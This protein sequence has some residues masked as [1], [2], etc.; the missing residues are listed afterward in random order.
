MVA[1][2][3]SSGTATYGGDSLP[4][5]RIV[6]MQ[7]TGHSHYTHND[8]STFAIVGENDGIVSPEVMKRRIINL[9]S[10]GIDTEFHQYPNVG[11]GFGLGTGTSAEGWINNAIKFWETI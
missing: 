3:G 8:P 2:I 11:H 4:K 7:Y 6:V 10:A 9:R 5:P 1:N